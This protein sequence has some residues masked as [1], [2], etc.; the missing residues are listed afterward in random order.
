MSLTQRARRLYEDRRLAA[1]W[2]LAVRY[3]RA[4]GKWIADPGTP[5]P[6]WGNQRKEAA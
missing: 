4:R 1:R 6:D 5:I 2:V 3:L